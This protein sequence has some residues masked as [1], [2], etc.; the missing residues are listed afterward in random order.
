M[1]RGRRRG[2]ARGAA[3]FA[4]AALAGAL[5]VACGGNSEP[6]GSGSGATL[7]ISAE[8]GDVTTV[9][10]RVGDT[11]VVSLDANATTGYAWTFTAGDTFAIESSDYVPDP[12]PSGLAGS[13]GTQVVKLQITGVGSS[14]LSGVYARSWETAS[15]DAGPDFSM[16]VTGLE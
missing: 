8:P 2:F 4:L 14:E 9:E 1:V 3:A 12:N 6:A 16:T 11:V 5:L 15:P 13:G 10:A 7:R